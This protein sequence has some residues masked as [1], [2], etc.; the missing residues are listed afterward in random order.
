MGASR[1]FTIAEPAAQFD[2]TTHA[3]GLYDD[4]GPL[5]PTRAG[6]HRVCSR[7][8]R[9]RLKLTLRGKRLE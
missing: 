7:R 4:V 8:D 3:I 2:A 9:A 6:R 1:T 5:E